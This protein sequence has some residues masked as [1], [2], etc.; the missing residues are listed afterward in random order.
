M[1]LIRRDPQPWTTTR[2][3]L[4]DARLTAL[5]RAIVMRAV[6]D[7]GELE[8][9]LGSNRSPYIDEI[10][11]WAKLEPPQYW[12]ALWAGRVWADAGAVI[13][14]AFPSCDAWLPYAVPMDSLAAHELIGCAVLYGVPGDARHIEIITRATPLL[15][16]TGGNRGYAGSGTNNGVCVDTAPL[17]RTD[18]LGVVRPTERL[19]P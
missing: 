18:V 15:L 1:T 19:T 10:T 11:R 2:R 12:C 5:Q 6:S 14:A 17:T 4:A 16:T 13:P 3:W 7:D 9:P 8:T